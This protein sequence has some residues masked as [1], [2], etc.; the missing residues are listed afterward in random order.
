MRDEAMQGGG[1]GARYDTAELGSARKKHRFIYC[2]VIAGTC[3]EVVVLERLKYATIY[4]YSIY[5]YRDTYI[6]V[7]TG[8]VGSI[9]ASF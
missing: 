2:C 9:S 7:N 5:T 4:I 8:Q 1:G 6:S 3:F